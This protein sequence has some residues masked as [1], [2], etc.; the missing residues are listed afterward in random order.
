MNKCG[1]FFTL[2]VCLLILSAYG[3]SYG[4]GNTFFF[5]L[6]AYIPSEN[7]IKTGYGSGLGTTFML[8]QN[9]VFSLEFKYGRFSVDPEEGKFLAGNLTLTP[10][11]ANF[12]YFF[13]PNSNFSPYVFGGACFVFASFKTSARETEEDAIITRQSP[14]DGLG[15]Q[16]GLGATYNV[17]E[18]LAI[19]FEGYYLYRKTVVE[20]SFLTGATG[21]FDT[22]LSH[23]GVVVGLKY[24]Y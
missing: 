23:L 6:T 14:K 19:Y 9:V 8:T 7:Q 11:V 15:F 5:G 18:Q 4:P 20:T 24:Y 22:N 2:S 13:N 17:T 21:Q 10:I 1:K 3:F 16:G 12:Q